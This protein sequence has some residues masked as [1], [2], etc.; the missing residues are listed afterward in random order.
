MNENENTTYQW[1]DKQNVVHPHPM[2]YYWDLKK[3]KGN[4][5]ICYYMDEPWGH[6]T[7]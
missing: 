3:K 6:Y 7:K 2:Q 4:S 1:M 5:V